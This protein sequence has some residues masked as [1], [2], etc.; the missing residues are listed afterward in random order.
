MEVKKDWLSGVL[1]VLLCF[2]FCV[3]LGHGTWVCKEKLLWNSGGGSLSDC[4]RYSME[5]WTVRME[6]EKIEIRPNDNH[7]NRKYLSVVC[8]PCIA[9][10]SVCS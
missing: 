5:F 2:I 1:K 4:R 10:T 3:S 8:I 9:G 6:K 7:K